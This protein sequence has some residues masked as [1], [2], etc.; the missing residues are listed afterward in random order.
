MG[1]FT[2]GYRGEGV[3]GRKI[4]IV[5]GSSVVGSLISLPSSFAFALYFFFG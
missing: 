4:I 3:R 2:N 1:G 5:K